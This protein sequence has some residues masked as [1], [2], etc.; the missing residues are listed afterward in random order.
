MIRVS[1]DLTDPAAGGLSRGFL[2]FTSG[3]T[4]YSAHA[5]LIPSVVLL[6]DRLR[7]WCAT[8]ASLLDFEP[9]DSSNWLKF[10]RRGSSV[11]LFGDGR[12]VGADEVGAILSE[13]REAAM[14]LWR[15]VQRHSAT[16]DAAASD[17]ER[18][19]REWRSTPNRL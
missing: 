4:T 7:A 17:L 5:L 13:L 11:L 9:L 14:N 15:S 6:L 1:F 19:V 8:K 10:E 3:D 16:S 12:F 18:L 2:S